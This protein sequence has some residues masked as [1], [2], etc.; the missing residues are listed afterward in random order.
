MPAAALMAADEAHLLCVALVQHNIRVS[1][2][3]H[4]FPEPLARPPAIRLPFSGG[5]YQRRRV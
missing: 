3:S 4:T 5:S 1:P 2:K